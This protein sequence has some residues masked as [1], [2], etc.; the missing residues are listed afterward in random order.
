MLHK[1]TDVLI[2]YGS[3]G[4][5]LLSILESSG[6]P[7]PSGVDF[8]L[9]G[10]AASSVKQP[11]VAYFTALLAV[12]GST[13][14]NFILFWG[15]RHGR[16]VFGKADAPAGKFR[17]WYHRYGL[18]TVFVP[19]VTPIVPLPLKVFVISAGAF[20]SPLKR[21]LTVILV[22]RVIRYFGEAW[23]GLQLGEDAKGF[24]IRNGWTLAG[25]ALAMT[26]ALL[27]LIKVNDRRRQAM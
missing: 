25:V 4:V 22:A 5:L 20:H 19:A 27:I 23:L 8:L 2:A 11:H 21:F 17:K 12:L 6:I 26:F 18:L 14:G 1:I 24:L 13:A 16:R 9:L 15:A 3:W 10:V 7:I